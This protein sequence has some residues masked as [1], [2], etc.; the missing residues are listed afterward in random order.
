MNQ[1]TRANFRTVADNRGTGWRQQSFD[2][3][4]AV[5]LLYLIEYGSWYSQSEIGAGLTD[6][7]SANWLDWNNYNPIERTGLSNGLGNATGNVSNGSN[8]KG[9]YM[10]YRGIE[11]FFGHLWKWVDGFN[12][13]SNVP[14]VCN[15]DT[16]FADGTTTNYTALGVTLAGSSGYQKALEQI[17]RGFLPASVGGSSSTYITD[18]YY[19]ALE[20]RVAAL[21]GFAC[22]GTS[23][24]VAA[25][26]LSHSSGFA[27]RHCLGRLSQ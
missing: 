16:H 7:S 13:N 2:L 5:Q 1:G 25:W 24:G 23:G 6:W 18:Y 26:H 4:S 8:T 3:V 15:N 27:I 19:Q 9:S 12:I 11:N 17:A 10:S 20:W 14:Y 22:D 21:G